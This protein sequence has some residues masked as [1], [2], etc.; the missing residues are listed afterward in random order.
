MRRTVS[1]RSK[2][3]STSLTTPP[4]LDFDAAKWRVLALAHERRN[5]SEYRGELNVDERLVAEIIAIAGEALATI[6]KLGQPSVL[7]IG[8]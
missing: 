1:S 3:G 7:N 4:T 5:Q 6:E 2:A 8:L